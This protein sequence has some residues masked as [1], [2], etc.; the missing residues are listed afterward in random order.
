MLCAGAFGKVSARPV[1]EQTVS[2]NQFSLFRVSLIY[3]P[4]RSSL[5]AR[6]TRWPPQK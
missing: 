6:F 4:N 5:E 1:K 3:T 2:E